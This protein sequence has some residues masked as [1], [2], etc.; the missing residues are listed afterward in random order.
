MTTM[1][2]TYAWKDNEH[3]D[4]DFIAQELGQAGLQ[5]RLDRWELVPGKLL[6][7]QIGHF[8]SDPSETDAWMIYATSSSLSSEPCR[9][10]L[11]VA[12]DRALNAPGTRIP[13]K[14][15]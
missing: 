10:E 12:I 14:P 1:W 15:L 3:R 6:W 11:Y 13:S 4:V 7:D 2:L 5:V 9:E 8:I